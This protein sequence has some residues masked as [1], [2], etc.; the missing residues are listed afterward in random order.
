MQ[1]PVIA[2]NTLRYEKS[3]PRALAVMGFHHKMCLSINAVPAYAA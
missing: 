1:H 2:T 3:K